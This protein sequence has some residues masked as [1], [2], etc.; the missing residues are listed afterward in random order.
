MKWVSLV[1][2]RGQASMSVLF[3]FFLLL[4][5]FPYLFL[6]LFLSL[7]LFLFL[8]P[9]ERSGKEGELG[10]GELEVRRGRKRGGEPCC[11]SGWEINYGLQ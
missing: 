6:F 11:R 1:G 4:F 2:R 3:F 8:F 10:G 5:S 9:F 7:F